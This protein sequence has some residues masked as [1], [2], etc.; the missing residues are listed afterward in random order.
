MITVTSGVFAK[1]G[2]A[3]ISFVTSVCPSAWNSLAPAGD[4][5]VKVDIEYFSKIRRENE[6][7]LM[8]C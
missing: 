1:L 4:I 5:L 8:F 7:F 2:N 6:F 3:T